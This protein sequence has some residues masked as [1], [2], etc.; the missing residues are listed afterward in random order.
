MDRLSER[1]R[2]DDFYARAVVGNALARRTM[3]CAA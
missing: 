3:H 2:N 1:L